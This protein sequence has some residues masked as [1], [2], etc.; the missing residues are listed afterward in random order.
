MNSRI[1]IGIACVA[2]RRLRGRAATTGPGATTAA[3]TTDT[4]PGVRTAGAALSRRIPTTV[5]RRCHQLSA[6]IASTTGS[7]TSASTDGRRS[8]ISASATSP[9]SSPSIAAGSRAPTRWMRCCWR[10]SS[11][12]SAGNSRRS[13]T[14]AGIHSFIH[15]SPATPCTACSRAISRPSPNA[16]RSS[17]SDSTNCRASSSQVR[18]SLV[19]AR[20]PKVHA[21]TAVKQNAGL[22]SLLDGEI[23]QRIA[24]LPASDQEGLRASVTRARSALSQHQIWLEKRLAARGRAATFVSARSST[25]R[26][27]RTRCSRRCRARRSARGPKRSWPRRGGRCTTS[28]ARC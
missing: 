5:A 16:C 10:T 14:G 26:S 3:S 7:T 24:A 28:R 21:E 12:T 11:S 19:P 15:G 22:L 8:W 20:V 1:V 13:R 2:A 4:R 18:E 6:I 9:R 23:A 25:T 27:S 17:A